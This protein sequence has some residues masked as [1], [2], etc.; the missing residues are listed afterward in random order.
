MSRLVL[1]LFVLAGLSACDGGGAATAPDVTVYHRCGDLN[2]DELDRCFYAARGIDILIVGRV[3]LP[4]I[5]KPQSAHAETGRQQT[6]E[7][8]GFR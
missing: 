1:L 5:E 2:F 4:R 7:C 3:V 8:P 6:T